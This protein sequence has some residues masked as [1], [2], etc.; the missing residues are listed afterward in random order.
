VDV[1]V[2][3]RWW[4]LTT[5]ILLACAGVDTVLNPEQ[6][7]VTLDELTFSWDPEKPFDVLHIGA[8]LVGALGWPQL[9]LLFLF[10]SG[11]AVVVVSFFVDDK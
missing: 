5:V 11:L 1:R 3:L 2:L 6:A 7:H 8:R 9:A 10:G 4:V